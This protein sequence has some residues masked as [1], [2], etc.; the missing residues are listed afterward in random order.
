MDDPFPDG[1]VAEIEA[2]LAADTA[3]CGHDLYDAVFATNT[4][5]PLQRK[6]EMR[7]MMSLA[8]QCAPR[9]VMEIGTDKAGGLYHWCKCL[10]SV[11]RVIACE[12][13]G[14]PYAEA[15]EAAFPDIDFL[16]LS[17]SSYEP[18][19]VEYVYRWL[20]N[21]SIDRLFLDGDKSHFLKDFDA[22]L[23]VMM[24]DGGIIFLHDITDP[25][26]GDA[27][28]VLRERGFKTYTIIETGEWK[29]V[30]RR[31][32]P[33]TAHEHWLMTWTGRSCGVGVIFV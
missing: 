29:D 17:Q 23:P 24:N 1:M 31:G 25:T 20:G 18:E 30:E 26:P 10:P 2:F 22:Y 28:Q 6:A 12:I 7:R 8:Q 11:E 5:F 27:F 9:V 15:F 32:G 19:T 33:K 14:V 13:R 3:P 21:D 4:M 16:W